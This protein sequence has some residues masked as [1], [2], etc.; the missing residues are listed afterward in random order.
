M[1]ESDWPDHYEDFELRVRRDDSV[2]APQERDVPGMSFA[3]VVLDARDASGRRVSGIGSLAV[4]VARGYAALFAERGVSAESDEADILRAALLPDGV[5]FDLFRDALSRACDGYGGVRL[6]LE[7][8]DAELAAVPWELAA[9][10]VGF[11][12]LSIEAKYL[13]QHPRLSVVRQSEDFARPDRDGDE[14][15]GTLVLATALTVHG[16]VGAGT[17]DGGSWPIAK[18]EDDMRASATETD[19]RVRL[20]ESGGFQVEP[21]DEPVDRPS[22]ERALAQPAWGFYFGG[23]GTPEGIVVA[24]P[25]G[26]AQ[27]I[28]LPAG[29]LAQLL[30]KAGVRVAILAACDTALPGA[31][32]AGASSD[33]GWH[34]VAET[35]VRLG[36]PYVIGMR[37]PIRNSTALAM[38]ATLCQSLA[39]HGS[40]ERALA[41]V[42]KSLSQHWW[43]P[44]LHIGR[45]TGEVRV[46]PRP[47]AAATV[48]LASLSGYHVPGD[49]RRMD[50]RLA[51]G[52]AYP[53]RLDV[54]WGLD[55]GP[56]RGVFAD[57]AATDLTGLL[58]S[59]EERGLFDVTYRQ[60]RSLTRMWPRRSWYTLRPRGGD[61]PRTVRELKAWL[62]HPS[63]GFVDHV[64]RH[65]DGASIGIVVPHDDAGT[66]S[67]GAVVTLETVKSI[68]TVLSGAAVVVH[69][70]PGRT[71][72]AGTAVDAIESA[73]RIG[74]MLCGEDLRMPWTDVTIV[75]RD[76]PG[77]TPPSSEAG[78]PAPSGGLSLAAIQRAVAAADPR[79][80]AGQPAGPLEAKAAGL[81]AEWAAQG[82]ARWSDEIN[83]LLYLRDHAAGE[84]PGFFEAVLRAHA[85][86]RASPDRYASLAVAAARDRD[87]DVWL[88]A[89]ESANSPVRPEA[90]P[91]GLLSPEALDAVVVGLARV[92]R[93]AE[94]DALVDAWRTRASDAALAV[95][96][97]RA[98]MLRRPSESGSQRDADAGFLLGRESPRAADLALRA[99]IGVGLTLADLSPGGVP[100]PAAWALL[101]RHGLDDDVVRQIGTWPESL[102]RVLGFAHVRDELDSEVADWAASYRQLFHPVF[103]APAPF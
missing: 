53:A 32:A 89:A 92:G 23:H 42:R 38:T 73:A 2:L 7:I 39:D 94:A 28:L 4:D 75:T 71:A 40:V 86:T 52:D 3:G 46:D 88:A 99:G 48:D 68:G 18:M 95:L 78:A 102:R 24:G 15:R 63:A 72:A 103:P 60:H 5:V 1:N 82:M 85:G 66:S 36:V 13:V 79:S 64:E 27:P 14:A 11:D 98:S 57:V 19:R 47:R 56:L 37:G 61:R 100:S 50:Q 21:G 80:R 83:E 81:L 91:P 77:A 20:L 65:P 84:P 35:L 51:P 10:P 69:V 87:I 55:R 17:D 16:V 49:W 58:R 12:G 29:E 26:A 30:A 54:L 34:S 43:L 25:G 44:V 59:V 22:L 45:G 8:D 90:I 9:L 76:L 62:E 97:Y 96:R 74:Q 101:A 70:R 67:E 6:R 33:A 93:P 31:P 41:Q